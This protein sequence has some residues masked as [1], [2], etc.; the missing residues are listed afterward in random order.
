V[1][2]V[3]SRR[4]AH[5]FVS[6]FI[7]KWLAGM[8]QPGR[9]KPVPSRVIAMTRCYRSCDAMGFSQRQ[10][11]NPPAPWNVRWG[12][13]GALGSIVPTFRRKRWGFSGLSARL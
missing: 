1:E 7:Q 5:L 2:N 8:R 4:A 3:N 10:G 12:E 11:P 9:P 6:R 13:T